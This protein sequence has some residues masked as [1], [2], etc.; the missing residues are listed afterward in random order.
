MPSRTRRQRPGSPRSGKAAQRTPA[1][2]Q[3]PSE[4]SGLR[5]RLQLLAGF[6]L[7]LVVL[8]LWLQ[9]RGFFASP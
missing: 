3:V 6:L 5:P 7:P 4:G 9:S 8:G 2:S 1:P